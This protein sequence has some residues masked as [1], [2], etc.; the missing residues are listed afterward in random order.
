MQTI[1]YSDTGFEFHAS[2]R[3]I[4]EK[5]N[6]KTPTSLKTFLKVSIVLTRRLEYVGD[7]LRNMNAMFRNDGLGFW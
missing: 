6:M 3:C 1:I 4:S 5:E 2:A 7:T